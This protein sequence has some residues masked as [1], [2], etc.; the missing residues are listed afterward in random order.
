MRV[1]ELEAYQSPWLT[2]SDLKGKAQRVRIA[3]WKIEEVRQ[4][5][6]DKV[7]KVALSFQGA[8][9]R[10]LLN[11]TQAKVIDQAF[12]EIDHWVGRW[13]VLQPSRTPQGQETIEIVIPPA[14]S[15]PT[16]M[17]K[18]GVDGDKSA[19]PFDDAPGS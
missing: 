7:R 8:K 17:A 4:R 18:G 2:V 9:K 1:T 11:A 19:N 3:G 10:M 14:A 5:D 12:G 15:T 6:G 13:M 16:Q